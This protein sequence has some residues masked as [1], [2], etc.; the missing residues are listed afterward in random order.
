MPEYK[1]LKTTPIKEIIFNI[2]YSENIKNEDLERFCSVP[3]ILEEFKD[4][5]QGFAAN[6]KAGKDRALTTHISN[7]GYMLK[8]D[9]H[10]IQVKVGSFAFHKVKGYE[11]FEGLFNRLSSFWK[12]YLEVT[13]DLTI[14]NISLRYLNFI[15][16][17]E[18]EDVDRLIH[19]K[20]DHPY[21]YEIKNKLLQLHFTDKNSPDLNINVVITKGKDGLRNGLILDIFLNH[22]IKDNQKD[23][24]EVFNKFNL[25]R[26]VKNDIFFKTLTDYTLNKYYGN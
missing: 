14:N 24:S 22:A 11:D 7:D 15:E 8:S 19:V 1:K 13:G 6:I 2:S 4:V 10:V 26:E 25:M 5:K 9:M 17:S 23:Y 21:G 3:E 20:V 12:S 18:G 16:V